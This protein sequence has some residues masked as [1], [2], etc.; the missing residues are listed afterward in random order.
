MPVRLVPAALRGAALL[1]LFLLTVPTRSAFAQSDAPSPCASDAYRQF[2][3]WIGTWDVRTADGTL[4]GTNRIS[5]VENGCALL[6]RWTGARGGTGMSLNY[7][8]PSAN[9]WK[10]QWVAQAGYLIEIEG[11]FE[12][13]TLAMDG[14]LIDRAG[15]RHGFRGMWTPLPDGRVRQYFEQQDAEGAWQPWFEGFYT[16]VDEE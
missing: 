7:Y 6:E 15:A 10:Q 16:R 9:T 8:D 1:S 3:F 14:T 5:Q 12:D 4:A 13:G 2:D 11:Q